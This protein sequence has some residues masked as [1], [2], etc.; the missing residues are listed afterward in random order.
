MTFTCIHCGHCTRQLWRIYINS[1]C[2]PPLLLSPPPPR[3]TAELTHSETPSSFSPI[4][5]LLLVPELSS[6]SS[7]HPSLSLPP[8]FSSSYHTVAA[9]EYFSPQD[10]L[11]SPN[12]KD[13][14]P[15]SFKVMANRWLSCSIFWKIWARFWL[16]PMVY[17]IMLATVEEWQTDRQNKRS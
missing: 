12:K 16:R 8:F 3:I 1:L 17:L 2:P 13:N 6:D 14:S 9:L 15:F 5:L 10:D 11:L 4:L 7:L